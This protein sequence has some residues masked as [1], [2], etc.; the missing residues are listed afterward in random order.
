M[1][2]IVKIINRFKSVF[3]NK[4]FQRNFLNALPFWIGAIITGLFSV[5]YAKL[6][7]L[8]EN[9]AMYIFHK[10]SWL[11]F[12][13]TPVT[14]VLAWWIVVKYS[15]YARGSGIPQVTAA[16]ELTNPAHNYKVNK[17]LGIKVIFVKLIS[18]LIMIFGGGVIGR[19]GPTIQIS[20]SIFKA[21]NDFLPD[22]FPKISKRN[23]IVTG[24]AAGLASAFN[25]PLGGIVFAIE[26][27]TRT[28]FNFFKSALLTGV[29]IAGL[30][31]LNLL[32]PYLYLGY[33]EISG[34]SY[35]LILIIIPVA[36]ITGISGSGMGKMILFIF[37]R[38]QKLNS[39]KKKLIY[40]IVCGLAIAALAVFI[41]SRTFGSGKEIMLTT[42]FT[43]EKHLEWYIPLL[44]IIGPII[45]FS[46]GA[47]GG[48]FAPSLSAG[49]SIGAVISGWLHLSGSE[50]NLI[51]LC[52]MVGFLTGITR[53]P[54]T[55]SILVIE[56]TNNHNIIFNLMLTALIANLVS[57]IISRH[58]FYDQLRDRY[59][60]EILKTESQISENEKKSDR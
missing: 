47:A 33:P 30:T 9:G 42:L 13:I 23:M 34:V 59:L 32:G 28:H 10:A 5:L 57:N 54:F 39:N 29:I 8:A 46:T 2:L 36:L 24:A 16:I 3:D 31:A 17:L 48:I 1:E 44:R 15:P 45:S 6:F 49:A 58:S 55:S 4:K 51:I 14:F 27:L 25:T 40:T 52:G 43:K 7:L 19:E 20:A 53:S 38:K 37:N 50:T 56:M 22:W 18:S 11:F 41:D 60:N 26:E 35:W 21:I 12:I